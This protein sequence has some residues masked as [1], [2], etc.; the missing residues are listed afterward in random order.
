MNLF[1]SVSV[2]DCPG[3]NK[4]QKVCL[5]CSVVEK[6]NLIAEANKYV[7]YI[8]LFNINRRNYEKTV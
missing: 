4:C 6:E 8:N 5:S 2:D 7:P 3:T 1:K